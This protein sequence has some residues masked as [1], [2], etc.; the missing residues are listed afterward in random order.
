MASTVEELEI[1]H[2]TALPVVV[3]VWEVGATQPASVQQRSLQDTT[4]NIHQ[5][6]SRNPGY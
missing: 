4:L 1:L 5:I 3:W 6:E 2:L